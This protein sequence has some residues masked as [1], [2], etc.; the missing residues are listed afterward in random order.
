V[1][2]KKDGLSRAA[3]HAY[4]RQR[5]EFGRDQMAEAVHL[6]LDTGESLSGAAVKAPTGCKRTTGNRRDVIP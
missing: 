1:P 3:W 4:E 2:P 5:A 6:V